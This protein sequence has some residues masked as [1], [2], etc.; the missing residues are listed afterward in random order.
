MKSTALLISVGLALATGCAVGPDYQKPRP[1]ASQPAPAQFDNATNLAIWKPAQPSADK[2]RGH[3]WGGFGDPELDRLETLAAGNNATLA[4][5]EARL[6][7]AR[8]LLKG[9]RADYFPQVSL[10]P[11]MTEQATSQNAPSQGKAAGT[12]YE[13]QTWNAP[14]VA[15]WELDLWGRVRRL[16]EAARARFTAQTDDLESARLA[17]QSELAADYFQLRSIQ[18]ERDVISNTIRVYQRSLDLVQNRRAA[19]MVSDLDLAQAQTQLRS[20]QAQL[21]PLDQS[22]QTTTHALAVLCG[23]APQNLRVADKTAETSDLAIPAAL[24]SELLERRP[25]IAGAERRVAAANADIGVAKS[26]YYPR[27]MISGMAGFQSVD[28]DTLFDWPS[29]FWSVG[30]SI[31]LPL[32][33]GGRTRSQVAA[34]RANWEAAVNDYRGAVLNAFRE[35]EDNLVAARA[36][37]DQL[38]A[39]SAALE[40][41]RRLLEIANNRYAAGLNTYLDVATAQ[42]IALTHERTVVQ[43]QSKR[44]QAQV[45]LVRSTGGGWK[46]AAL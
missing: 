20:A 7:A 18:A 1:L 17:M 11:G 14:L 21:P 29:K 25:D 4:A 45:A 13:Y 10:Q 16:N 34:N 19:G 44:R 24:P 8:Q 26:A 33:T 46:A 12:T 6:R 2:P 22:I 38:A 43:L 3:W 5:Q 40:S 15:S 42:T 39:E 28:A 23:M 41:A 30:P 36:I 37:N 35:V 27:I 32:F 31:T 9:V